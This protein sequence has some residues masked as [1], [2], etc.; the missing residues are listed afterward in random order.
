MT[1]PL[2]GIGHGLTLAQLSP[3][4]VEPDIPLGVTYAQ[5]DNAADGSIH[6]QGLH[7]RLRWPVIDGL[8]DL[9]ATLAQV[10]LEEDTDTRAA[11]TVYLPTKRGHWHVYDAWAND[12][13][14]ITFALWV[15]G[16][17]VML[18]GLILTD[19]GVA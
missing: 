17:E 12:P 6:L 19:A 18:N 16:V 14:D 1:T 2:I 7:C 15:Q 3:F 10:G 9:H 13:V 5:R 11:V 4:V 8:D